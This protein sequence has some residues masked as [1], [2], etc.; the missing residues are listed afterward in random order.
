MK[1]Y[2]NSYFPSGHTEREQQ[3]ESNREREREKKRERERERKRW[4]VNN[5]SQISK[6]GVKMLSTSMGE[7]VI[8]V[9]A[10]ANTF[11]SINPLQN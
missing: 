11:R 5:E 4:S 7:K 2:T 1:N 10:A 3:R 8:K 6:I 9:T